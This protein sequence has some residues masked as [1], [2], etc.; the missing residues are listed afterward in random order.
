MRCLDSIKNSIY[1]SILIFSVACQSG[2]QTTTTMIEEEVR[3]VEADFN[4]YAAEYG[5]KAAFVEYADDSA[6]L[7]R[8]GRVLKGKEAIAS[9]FD[10]FDYESVK[11]TWEPDF[12]EVA[13]SGD[14]AY[15]YGKFTFISTDS[16][17]VEQKSEGIFHTVWK[18]QRDGKW[19]YVWD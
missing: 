3:K 6:A 8:R 7:N 1:V 10:G 14:L 4:N 5:L 16:V 13:V 11:L 19:K 18:K 9:Y 12:V 17:G 2:Q 15:T